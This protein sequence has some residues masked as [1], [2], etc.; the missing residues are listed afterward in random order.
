MTTLDYQKLKLTPQL[1][2]FLRTW[3]DVFA[4]T[5]IKCAC[6]NG[7]PPWL[8]ASVVIGEVVAMDEW[9]GIDERTLKGLGFGS[10]VGLAQIRVDTAIKYGLTPLS[11]NFDAEVERSK[12]AEEDAGQMPVMRRRR[13]I[14]HPICT[15]TSCAHASG[16]SY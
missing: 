8:L 2:R 3:L 12:Q 6:C 14:A 7:I 11:A 5:L 10:S 9:L 15:K 1:D 16:E 13:A 4:P